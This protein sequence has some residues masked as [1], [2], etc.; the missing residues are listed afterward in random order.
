[1]LLKF[2]VRGTAI[3]QGSKVLVQRGK[4]TIMIDSNAHELHAWRDRVATAAQLAAGPNWEPLNR[5]LM[6]TM[7]VFFPKPPGTGFRD[8]PAGPPDTDKLQ[9]AVGDALTQSGVIKDDARIVQWI[10]GKRW[11]PDPDRPFTAVRI[12]D[13]PPTGD[14][15]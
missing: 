2:A 9:R 12:A 7:L 4:K 5:P 10:A 15:P 3:P 14:Q 11:A 6:V 8:Y 1:L 13:Y